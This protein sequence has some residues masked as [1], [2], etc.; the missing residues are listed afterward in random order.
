MRNKIMKGKM[1]KFCKENLKEGGVEK[2]L[3]Y[4]KIIG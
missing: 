4:K 3:C 2:A 1:T